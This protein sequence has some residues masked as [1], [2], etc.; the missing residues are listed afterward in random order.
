MGFWTYVA[1]WILSG[2]VGRIVGS[3]KNAAGMGTLFGFL[4]GPAGAIAAGFLDGRTLCATCGTR[5]NKTPCVCPACKTSIDWMGKPHDH[6]TP[7]W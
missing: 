2:V 1:A 5:L 6:V 4:L 7:K 3:Q